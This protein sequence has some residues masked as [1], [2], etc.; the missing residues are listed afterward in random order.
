MKKL[1]LG[2]AAVFLCVGGTASGETVEDQ[3]LKQLLDV[4][5]MLQQS[6]GDFGPLVRESLPA[7]RIQDAWQRARPGASIREERYD[8]RTEIKVRIREGAH[9]VVSLPEWERVS[10]A[11]VRVGS[12]EA[13]TVTAEPSGVG[14]RLVLIPG[15]AGYDST[16]SVI[17]D[18][19]RIYAFYVVVESDRSKQVPDFVVY[20]DARQP[21]NWEPPQKTHGNDGRSRDYLNEL[22]FDAS[23]AT[24]KFTMTGDKSIAPDNVMSDGL[25]TFL[26]Y[27]DLDRIDMPSVNRVQDG[28]DRPVNNRRVGRVIVVEAGVGEG[29]TL[30]TGQRTVCIRASQ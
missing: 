12:K 8:A 16:V 24:Y 23:K 29:L 5:R 9:T 21:I 4:D 14:N 25:F 17:G 3:A 10:A 18:S 13:L 2:I 1:V 26:F 28:V 27:S 20:I 15:K 22:P 7:G 6:G 30:R 19:G 11:N